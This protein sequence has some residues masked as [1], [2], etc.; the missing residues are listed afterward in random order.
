MSGMLV[1]CLPRCLP[2][3]ALLELSRE[4]VDEQPHGARRRLERGSSGDDVIDAGP[5]SDEIF[6]GPGNDVY[7]TGTG[8]DFL[9]ATRGGTDQFDGGPGRDYLE[10]SRSPAAVVVNLLLAVM[11]GGV[12]S[13]AIEGIERIDGTGFD[14]TL[15]G[16]ANK[17]FLTGHGGDD[18]IEGGDGNDTL[19]GSFGVDFI[20][21]GVGTDTCFNGDTVFNCEP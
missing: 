8:P 4:R 7:R 15:I 2:R 9:N 5:G 3:R 10:T 21:G 11:S 1:P 12:G 19:D 17:N 16:D 13:D 18:H 14:D 20:D 6:D